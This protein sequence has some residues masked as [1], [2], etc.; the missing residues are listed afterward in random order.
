[1]TIIPILMAVYFIIGLGF[2]V[3][4]LR[5]LRNRPK[6]PRPPTLWVWPLCVVTWPMVAVIIIG[7]YWESHP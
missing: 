4:L 2:A 6:Y 3:G 7:S 1:M 5:W